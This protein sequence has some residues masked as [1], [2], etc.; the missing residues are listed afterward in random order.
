M[1]AIALLASVAG[2]LL[3]P[4]SIANFRDIGGLPAANGERRM[5][6]GLLHRCASPANASAIDADAVL[7]ELNMRV[8]LDLRGE[9]DAYRD[10]GPRRLAPATRFLPHVP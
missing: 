5:R 9:Q 6:S 8:V 2:A 1:S 10:N 4:T 7:Q 3:A